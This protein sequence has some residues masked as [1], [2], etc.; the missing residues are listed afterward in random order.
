MTDT[1]IEYHYIGGFYI[2]PSLYM[3]QIF[4]QCNREN[5]PINGNLL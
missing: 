4:Q 1:L 2:Y 3:T 5:I